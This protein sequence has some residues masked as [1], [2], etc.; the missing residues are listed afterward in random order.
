M[1]PKPHDSEALLAKPGISSTIPWGIIVLAT[2]TLDDQPRAEM[3]KVNDIRPYR[4][5]AAKLLTGEPMPPQVV[6]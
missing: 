6:P 3:H 2:I 4:L 1:V 5:L